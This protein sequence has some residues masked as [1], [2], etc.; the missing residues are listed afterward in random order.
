MIKRFVFPCF[1]LFI[2][3]S[4]LPGGANAQDSTKKSEPAIKAPELGKQEIK[5]QNSTVL[6][7]N[8]APKPK[9]HLHQQ[10]PAT[11]SA[12]ATTPASL[13]AVS[14]DSAGKANAAELNSKSL[15]GQYQF[16]MTKVYHYQQPVVAAFW[17]NVSDTLKNI[18]GQMKVLQAKLNSQSKLT[19]SVKADADSKINVLSQPSEK[20]NSISFFGIMMAKTAYNLMMFGL[21]I[22]L[23][24]ALT[25]VVLATAKYKYEAKHRTDLYQEIEE[26]YKAFKVKANDKEKKLARELQ[27]ERN[28][29][30]EL[31]GRG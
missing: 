22:G 25:V 15:R 20:E 9:P 2:L 14:K 10:N 6:I 8:S 11:G 24:V 7:P 19:D 23:A 18:Q 5:A 16:L 21:V 13:K 17:K 26:E 4:L 12:S 1:F 30:D 27:T 29:L 28:K 3:F 31:L